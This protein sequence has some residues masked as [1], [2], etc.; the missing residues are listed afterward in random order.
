MALYSNLFFSLVGFVKDVSN[1]IATQINITAP[2]FVNLDAHA[3]IDS[4]PQEHAICI[5]GY[6]LHIN[7]KMITVF[8]AI[9]I[10]TFQDENL[11]L[12]T[13]MMDILTQRLLPESSIPIYSETSLVVPISHMIVASPVTIDPTA[14]TD[15][16][17]LQ[18]IMVKA[19]S[20][21]TVTRP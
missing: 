16:R 8:V 14:H 18:M 10:S 3:Q 7:D 2:T 6:A 5:Q 1:D 15:I 12:H 21:L 9:G 20:L 11:V 19:E 17:S 13:K 4:L